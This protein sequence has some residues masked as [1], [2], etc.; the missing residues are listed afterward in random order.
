M[1]W[2][3]EV[4]ENEKQWLVEDQEHEILWLVENKENEILWLVEEQKNEIF[5][6]VEDQVNK[7]C[8]W[9][10]DAGQ[11]R[12]TGEWSRLIGWELHVNEGCWLA[13][14]PKWIRD[15]DWLKITGELRMLVGWESQVNKELWLAENYRWTQDAGWLRTIHPVSLLISCIAPVYWL[16]PYQASLVIGSYYTFIIYTAYLV[17]LHI[18]NETCFKHDHFP[19]GNFFKPS[20]DIDTRLMESLKMF[21]ADNLLHS[22]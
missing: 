20:K 16:G 22:K 5:W 13:E 17:S 9:I 18:P 14:N 12:I 10:K 8:W 1:F 3:V 7:R 2:L 21:F 6:L 15:Y 11:V 19:T 4:Q